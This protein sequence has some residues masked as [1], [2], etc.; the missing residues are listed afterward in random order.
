VSTIRPTRNGRHPSG[1]DGRLV[2]VPG[3]GRR[4]DDRPGE[5][6]PGSRVVIVPGRAA[7]PRPPSSSSPPPGEGGRDPLRAVARGGAA[8]LVGAVVSTLANLLLSVIVARALSTND[9]GVFFSIT[10]LVLLLSTFGRLGTGNGLVYFLPRLRVT[11]S[12]E[13]ITQALRLAYR[14]TLW[15]SLGIGVLQFVLAPQVADLLGAPGDADAILVLRL[16]AVTLP[17]A[18]FGDVL[19]SA[20]RG[21]NRM[22]TTV[23]VE[24]I[25]RPA[26]QVVLIAAAAPTGSVV[27]LVLAWTVPYLPATLASWLPIRRLAAVDRVARFGRPGSGFD[28]REFWRFT[29]PR[30]ATA[31]VQIV[32][33][34][35]DVILVAA[36]INPSAAALYAAATRFLVVGQ[37]GSQAITLALQP[38][39]SAA[40]ARRDN[41]QA[42]TLYQVSTSWLVL[43]TWPLYLLVIA[44]PAGMLSIFGHRYTQATDVVV[45]LCAAML[46]A[47][48]CGQVDSVLM[49]AGRSTWNMGNAMLGLAV[50]VAVDLILLPRIGIRGAAIG[51][52]AA[53]LVNNL[54]PL[55]QVWFSTRLHP[56]GRGTLIGMVVTSVVLVACAAPVRLLIGDTLLAAFVAGVLG[57]L[58]L[59]PVAWAMRRPLGLTLFSL[60]R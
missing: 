32:L 5:D 8:N 42:N 18:A 2:I 51:W 53:I 45:I 22:R 34:R 11:G 55:S 21:F 46:V 30:A 40:L 12:P 44:F 6:G 3:R 17:F 31:L 1:P 14:P 28:A 9:A 41:G 58:V 54:L 15:T 7:P 4:T 19:Q 50:D 47:T 13:E 35:L 27:L 39:L 37:F 52:A 56:F 57:L 24:K 23:V 33:Q 43:L 38:R 25:G 26:A 48:A 20:T 36:I 16:I 29:G 10:S 59:A 49:M 60:R